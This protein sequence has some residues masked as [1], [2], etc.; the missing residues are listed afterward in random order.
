M[1]TSRLRNV[2][3]VEHDIGGVRN[4]VIVLRTTTQPQVG[5]HAV[6]QPVDADKHRP[7]GVGVSSVLVVPHLAI[8]VE[9]TTCLAS[10]NK[11]NAYAGRFEPPA[12][13]APAV[14]QQTSWVKVG[15]RPGV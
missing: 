10:A 9:G 4:E 5:K 13:T 1:V 15:P 2:D 6:H 14:S 12:A 8:A 3:I 7:Q 11:D